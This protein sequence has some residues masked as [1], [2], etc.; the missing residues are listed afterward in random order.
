MP[1]VALDL[2]LLHLEIGDRGQQLRVP[3]DQPLV[4]VDQAVAVELDEH[5][6]DRARQ[7]LVHGEAFA[8]PVAGG[9]EPLQLVD[10]G[11]AAFGLPLPD[12]FENFSRP[13]SRRP[14]SCRSINCRSTTIW[15]AMPA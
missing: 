9:A 2:D 7:A 11:A 3:V 5:L 14:G 13:M 4:L 6:G 8:R 1:E 12:A 15:V 10:D